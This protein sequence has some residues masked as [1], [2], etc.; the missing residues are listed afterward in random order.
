M[1]PAR[2]REIAF[3]VCLLPPRKKLGMQE[4]KPGITSGAASASPYNGLILQSPF[5]RVQAITVQ[6]RYT[7]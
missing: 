6:L 3:K 7:L 1:Q 2:Y 5:L 4:R